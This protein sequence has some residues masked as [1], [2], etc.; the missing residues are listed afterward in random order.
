MICIERI[1]TGRWKANCYI[2]YRQHATT[3]LVIDP[4]GDPAV[5]SQAIRTCGKNVAAF[6]ATHGHYDHVDAVGELQKEFGATLWMEA[7]DLRLIGQMNLYRRLFDGLP[8][9][10]LPSMIDS[11]DGG[12]T[13][14]FADLDIAVVAC[15]GHTSGSVSFHVEDAIFTGDTLMKGKVGDHHFPESDEPALV[16]SIHRLLRFPPTTRI[17]PGHGPPTFVV[18]EHMRNYSDPT[19]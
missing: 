17:F 14:F 1:S 13:R 6:L 18:D 19:A 4:G 7:K 5:I 8:P 16:N 3:C 11:F 2:V 15:P 10:T 9:A 12:E